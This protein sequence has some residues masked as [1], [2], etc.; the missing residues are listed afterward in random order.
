MAVKAGKATKTVKAIRQNGHPVA[1]GKRA[2]TK[3]E[4]D[5]EALMARIENDPNAPPIAKVAAAYRRERD[6]SGEPYLTIEQI[7]EQLGRQF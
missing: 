2:K 4:L 6:K 3:D 7:F 5:Y 1:K